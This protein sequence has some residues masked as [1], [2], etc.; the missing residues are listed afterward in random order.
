MR[1]LADE[2]VIGDAVRLLRQCGHDITWILEISPG[3]SD[4]DVLARAQADDRILLTLD[5]DFGE[6]AFRMRKPAS[7]GIVLLRLA[8]VPAGEAAT[9]IARVVESQPTWARTFTVVTKDRIRIIPLP[10]R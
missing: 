1:L 2:N 3:I 7:S 4:E 6:L 5:K 8:S 9:L 10:T